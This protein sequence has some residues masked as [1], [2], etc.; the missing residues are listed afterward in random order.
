MTN[1]VFRILWLLMKSG[2]FHYFTPVRQCKNKIWA[3]CRPC[4]AKISTSVKKVIYVIFNTCGTDV[5]ITVSRGFPVKSKNNKK[6]SMNS[7]IDWCDDLYFLHGAPAHKDAIVIDC[8]GRDKRLSVCCKIFTVFFRFG[9][10]FPR[11]RNVLKVIATR[12]KCTWECTWLGYFSGGHH[13]VKAFKTWIKRLKICRL[14]KITS[15]A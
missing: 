8:L 10:L 6:S 9:T 11:L 13:N 12:V 14:K 7:H 5:Q 3:I 15:K 1:T 4:I 2:L